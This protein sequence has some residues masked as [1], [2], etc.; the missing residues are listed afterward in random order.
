MMEEEQP[1]TGDEHKA[2]EEQP[3]PEEEHQDVSDPDTGVPGGEEPTGDDAGAY[4]EGSDVVSPLEQQIRY[5]LELDFAA[6]PRKARKRDEDI[7]IRPDQTLTH[8]MKFYMSVRAYDQFGYKSSLSTPERN[9]ILEAVCN[10]V[11]FDFG[12]TKP[13]G[14]VTVLAKFIDGT[15]TY[16]GE[17]MDHDPMASNCGR[18]GLTSL[19][20]RVMRELPQL[21]HE[22][23]RYAVNTL[24]KSAWK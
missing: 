1:A 22:M 17:Q 24:G 14:G 9:R 18:S 10:Q 12:C 2:I 4:G 15:I 3:E 20:D 13:M 21:L 23:W 8:D 19:V 11:C 6:R 5:A 16:G 7:R